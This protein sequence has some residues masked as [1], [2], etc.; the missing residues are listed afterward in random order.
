MPGPVCVP[1]VEFVVRLLGMCFLSLLVFFFRLLPRY[2]SSCPDFLSSRYFSASSSFFFS[3][4]TEGNEHRNDSTSHGIHQKVQSIQPGSTALTIRIWD[5]WE[6]HD[7]TINVV[8]K[9]LEAS[10]TTFHW[11]VGWGREWWVEGWRGRGRAKIFHKFD[12]QGQVAH[13]W[14]AFL[15]KNTF[16]GLSLPTRV[17]KTYKQYFG[18]ITS[19][20]F[21]QA[22]SLKMNMSVTHIRT[23]YWTMWV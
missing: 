23:Y 9:H 13:V 14:P 22:L 16:Q 19:C 12:R 21:H 1:H 4:A 11:G 3:A 10:N 17:S 8:S 6:C 5:V 15:H 7:T 2:F 20:H 18:A